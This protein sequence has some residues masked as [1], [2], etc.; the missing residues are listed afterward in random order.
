MSLFF[1]AQKK[2]G[3]VFV[4]LEAW[5]RQTLRNSYDRH[6][7][8]VPNLQKKMFF[9]KKIQKLEIIFRK[10]LRC[11]FVFY[12][13]F[14]FREAAHMLSCM[15]LTDE[16]PDDEEDWLELNNQI[17]WNRIEQL[18]CLEKCK[19]TSF[20]NVQDP[21]WW[22]YE[23]PDTQ[24]SLRALKHIIWKSTPKWYF[25]PSISLIFPSIAKG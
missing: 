24:G 3:Q 4:T 15:S 16:L 10:C 23:F 2:I 5:P 21:N 12:L 11:F 14:G 6:G 19:Q 18:E 22:C 7:L 25:R 17:T 1:F 20:S 9:Y 8:D 13:F